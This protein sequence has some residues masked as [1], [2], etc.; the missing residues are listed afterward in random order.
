MLEMLIERSETCISEELLF[1]IVMVGVVS[2]P[3]GAGGSTIWGGMT[4]TAGCTFAH[5]V[6]VSSGMLVEDVFAVI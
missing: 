1:W 6:T 2:P 3:N 4:I 5:A